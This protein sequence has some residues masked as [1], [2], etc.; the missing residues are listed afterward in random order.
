[1]TKR[2]EPGSGGSESEGKAQDGLVSV[3]SRRIAKGGKIG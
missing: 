3:L 2:E 1:M